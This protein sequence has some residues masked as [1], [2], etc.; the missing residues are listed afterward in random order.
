MRSRQQSQKQELESQTAID[1]QQIHYEQKR[2]A[3]RANL[4]DIIWSRFILI[5]AS[6]GILILLLG[7]ISSIL[8]HTSI[9]YLEVAGGT[10]TS[11]ISV[12]VH[13]PRK[14]IMQRVD[15]I[16]EKQVQAQNIRVALMVLSTLP[17]E[18]YER[19]AQTIIEK[20]IDGRPQDK[21]ILELPMERQSVE[22]TPQLPTKVIPDTNT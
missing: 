7:V 1:L 14:D 4:D 21:D 3:D 17:G 22:K 5:V 15:N 11:A 20:L 6:L 18:A 2:V 13:R 8:G 10:V 9:S 19:N 16:Y 12:L